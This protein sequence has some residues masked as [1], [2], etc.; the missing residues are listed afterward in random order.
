VVHAEIAAH[1]ETVV[2]V[3]IVRREIVVHVVH[4]EIVRREIVARVLHVRQAT[5]RKAIVARVPR[6][7]WVSG[8]RVHREARSPLRVQRHKAPKPPVKQL[9]RLHHLRQLKRLRPV[10]LRAS[11]GETEQCYL[12]R[13]VISTANSIAV[14]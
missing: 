9:S 6:D 4:A 10:L 2:L 5:V 1:A 13:H 12:H 11:R 3:A 8:P 14:A 7:Q